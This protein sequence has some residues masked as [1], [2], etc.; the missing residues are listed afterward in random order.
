VHA[1]S[2]SHVDLTGGTIHVREAYTDGIGVGTPKSKRSIRDAELTTSAIAVLGELLKARGVEDD[3]ALLFPPLM[4][5]PDGYRRGSDIAKTVLYP[6]MARAGIPRSGLHLTPPTDAMRTFHSLRHTYARIAL[7]HGVELSWLSRQ[8]GHSSTMVTEGRYGH[9]SKA[10]RK[11]EV[12][13]L[14]SAGSFGMVA[15]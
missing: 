5:T 12:A 9:W 3:S 6:A 10:A 15:S 8:M 1:G 7:E 2:R 4:P 11:R 13:K 14:E